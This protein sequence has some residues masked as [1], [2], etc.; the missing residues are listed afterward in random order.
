L[1]ENH[2]IRKIFYGYSEERTSKEIEEAIEK[3]L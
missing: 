2:I 3:L 1:D